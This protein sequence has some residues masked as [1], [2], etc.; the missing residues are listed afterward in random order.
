M[1]QTMNAIFKIHS[2]TINITGCCQV[3]HYNDIQ[4]AMLKDTGN[5]IDAL[6]YHLITAVV[7]PSYIYYIPG[8]LKRMEM[9]FLLW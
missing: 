7:V 6:T 5:I 4:C 2:E 9:G 1:A 8:I 3:D